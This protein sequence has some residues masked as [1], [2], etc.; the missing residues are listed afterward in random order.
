[1]KAP[2]LLKLHVAGTAMP[3][4]LSFGRLLRHY[5]LAMAW[6]QQQLAEQAGLSVEAVNTLERGTRR[7]PRSDTLTR[8]THALGLSP[9][10]CDRLMAAVARER[11]AATS[12]AAEPPPAMVLLSPL[13]SFIGRIVA[14]RAEW[15]NTAAIVPGD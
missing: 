13:T 12:S 1:M 8:L 10:E 4:E 3:P 14:H 2:P 11:D 7:A 9:A 5:R 6:S 15:L